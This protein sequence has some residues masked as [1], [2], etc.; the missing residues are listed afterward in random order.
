[1]RPGAI[2]LTVIFFGPSSRAIVFAQPTTPGR[3]AFESARLSTGSRTELDAMLTIRPWPLRSSWGRQRPVS[4]T[5]EIQRGPRAPCTP[6]W[7]GRNVHPPPAV[8]VTA[9]NA[10]VCGGA[11]PR[12][13]ILLV[14]KR[15]G[16]PGLNSGAQHADDLADRVG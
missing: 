16:T 5:S 9:K 2:V 15:P 4:L 12:T 1:M 13:R 11:A 10:R 7:V 14:R 8:S 3:T 6:P